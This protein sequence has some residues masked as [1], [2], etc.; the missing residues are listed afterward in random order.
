MFKVNKAGDVVYAKQFANYFSSRP[1]Q[2]TPIVL[3]LDSGID[4]A[5]GCAP[6]GCLIVAT[7][8]GC[9]G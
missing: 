8:M 1:T 9:V 7:D 5:G 6:A 3:T 4:T 2:W